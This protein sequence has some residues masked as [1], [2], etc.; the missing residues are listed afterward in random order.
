MEDDKRTITINDVVYQVAELSEECI[1]EL[2]S[3]KF[4]DEELLRL[5]FKTAAIT[6]AKNA[7]SVRAN[8]LLPKDEAKH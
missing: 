5:N 7:Y 1:R 4:C 6:T 2:S 8:E 3:V